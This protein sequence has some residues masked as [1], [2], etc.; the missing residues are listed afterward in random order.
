M[1]IIKFPDKEEAR[2]LMYFPGVS[3]E[4]YTAGCA[5]ARLLIKQQKK[6]ARRAFI[7]S[8]LHLVTMLWILKDI[9]T[10]RR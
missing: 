2:R 5:R 3:K 6:A 9:F 1:H 8:V 7:K 10:E 4:E